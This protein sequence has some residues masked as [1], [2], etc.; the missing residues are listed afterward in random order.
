[1]CLNMVSLNLRNSRR[2]SSAGR[3]ASIDAA[4]GWLVLGIAAL[5]GS[6]GCSAEPEA[7]VATETSSLSAAASVTCVTIQR[8]TLGAVKDATI[9][10]NAQR[11]NY[12]SK[13]VLRVSAKDE[14]LIHVELGSIP[15][16]AAI[17]SATLK[18]FVNGGSSDGT[19][20]LHRVLAPW[21]EGS[22]TFANFRQRFA[23]P[24][25]AKLRVASKQALKSVDL[26]DLVS[27]W[28]SGTHAN[29]GLLLEPGPDHRAECDR[30]EDEDR[31]VTIFVSSDAANPSKRPAL[32]VCYSL[33][34]DHCLPNP[35]LNGGICTNGEDGFSCECA[36]GFVG[37]T[38]ATNVDDCS[39]NPCQNGGICSDEVNGYSCS[40]PPGFSGT[41]CTINIDDC[42]PNPCQNGGVC[43]DELAA[44][45]CDCLPG[46][47][48]L[49][50]EHLID[51]CESSPCHNGGTCTS[52]VNSYTC[53]CAPGYT[54]TN[55]DI[56]VDDCVGNACLNG[57]TCVDEVNGYSC[58]CLPDFGGSRCEIN[59]NTCAQ[60]PCLNGA[61][62]TNVGGGYTCQC[63]AGYAGTNCEVDVDDCASQPCQNGGSCVDRVDSYTCTCPSGY[64]GA[65]C[66]NECS[67]DPGADV[68]DPAFVDAN[69][70]GVDGDVARSIFV[71][72]SG[73][74]SQECGLAPATPCASIG[75]GIARAVAT[76]RPHVLIQ[77]GR[78]L[79]VVA[80]ASD[81][82]L[83]G[84]YD[85][86]WSRRPHAEQ[87]TEIVG[88]LDAASG[89]YLTIRAHD[90]SSARL[91]NLVLVGPNAAQ[92]GH[93]SYVV[94]AF[95]ASA[96]AIR[97][98]LVVAGDG[99]DGSD[100]VAGMDAPMVEA[101]ASMA[102]QRGGAA[103]EFVASCDT[104]SHGEGGPGGT[105]VCFGSAS[106]RAGAGGDGGEMHTSCHFLGVCGNCNATSGDSGGNS[107]VFPFGRGGGGGSP[108][109]A[110]ADGQPGR[111]VNGS[112]G[113]GAPNA[114]GFLTLPYWT[115]RAGTAGGLGEDGSG[116][117]GGGGSGGCNDGIDSYGA[118]GGGG[119]AG[120]CRA[121]AG[122]AGG[123]AGGAS[124]GIFLVA[125]TAELTNVR[126]QRGR[127]GAGGAGGAGGRGQS[128]GSGAPGGASV[129]D[130]LAGGRGGD[131]R[132]GGHSG[133]GGGGAGG[134]SAALGVFQTGLGLTDVTFFGGDGGLG[135]SGGPAA[136]APA[137]EADG[138]PGTKGADG[139]IVDVLTCV[140][141]GGC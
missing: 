28:I 111:F 38:C 25:V 127:G 60:G 85:V 77:A 47:D 80:L 68:P 88:T 71:A 115:G 46:Y 134:P 2:Y 57:G 21:T 5:L 29:H 102:G 19:I 8:G 122:G 59:L 10:S 94:H 135:G 117:G 31:N 63:A 66:E 91:E 104:D 132:H 58:S 17:H 141:P 65:N 75:A 126:V 70:D 110:G 49:N 9:K 22:V 96:L 18:L 140:A 137:A 74:D 54:G 92:P 20:E 48:G 108:C 139:G 86:A 40:C 100:G 7:Q 76:A 4:L 113:V 107:S 128:A 52:G 62:C 138:A 53:T 45:S 67:S 32:E 30:D 23:E 14:A 119:G 82:G 12:G 120:G 1:V 6:A 89:S 109:A 78:Y 90:I 36:P 95:N 84:G 55:C 105:N 69:C 101:T 131:G 99:A 98:V 24:S 16:S 116:G 125:T 11:Q 124:F 118:G 112:A 103:D 41:N 35:C 73:S 43:N 39:T 133:G 123:G 42:S 79:E 26:T 50:C 33:P 87:R 81:V 121:R 15:R 93:S 34:T 72:G 130:S 13:P 27:K 51:N 129:G 64:F 106:P 136:S 114:R 44:H 56:N 97:D 83:F 37:E 61:T 3:N